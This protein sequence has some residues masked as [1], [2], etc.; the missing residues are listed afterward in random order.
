MLS[1]VKALL[2][3]LIIVAGIAYYITMS[4]TGQSDQALYLMS[5]W[6]NNPI[7]IESVSK[8][9]LS[10]GG[11][12][13][14]INKVDDI[15]TIDSGFF[16]NTASLYDLFQSLQMTEIVE[17]K[18][19][20]PDNHAQLELSE[21][22]LHVSFYQGED[23]VSGIYIGKNTSAGLFF[24]RKDNENQTYTVKGLKSVPFNLDSWQMKTVLDQPAA[25][26]VG[27]KFEAADGGVFE[28]ERNMDNMSFNVVDMP[29]GFQIKPDV[30]LN[31]L[32]AGLTQL[33][34]DAA[35]AV[36]LDGMVL[37]S[38]NTYQL[39]SGEQV[40]LQ[41]YQKDDDY[42]LTIDGENYRH[43]APWMMKLAAYKFNALNKNSEDFI[44]KTTSEEF[45]AEDAVE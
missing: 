27:V 24:V 28:V 14:L 41:I 19:A 1:N 26:V 5:D 7:A 12:N 32:A 34:I 30:Q 37:Q 18:T 31:S 8:V 10:K 40:K 39:N 42:F 43:F 16:A 3:L 15:W 38:T 22:D 20:N 45:K 44:E 9:Q 23:K 36:N 29:A 21:S 35:E 33:M 4:N 25:E 11:E 17:L 6:Q 13:I 2:G